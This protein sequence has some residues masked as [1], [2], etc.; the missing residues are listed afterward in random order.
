MA[1]SA[2]L[3]EIADLEAKLAQHRSSPETAREASEAHAAAVHAKRDMPRTTN[4][5]MA[6]LMVGEVES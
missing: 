3:Q 5:Q 2:R 4:M 1:E 6:D